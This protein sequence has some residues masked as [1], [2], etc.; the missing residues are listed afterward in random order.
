MNTS[1][2][3]KLATNI[4]KT[5]KIFKGV[6]AVNQLPS[7][8]KNG[9]FIVN[10]DP[11]HKP[12]SHWVAIEINCNKKS[13]NNYY[14]DSYGLPPSNFKI[15]RLL[16]KRYTFNKKKLQHFLSTACGQWCLYFLLRRAQKWNR[17][18]ITKP[19]RTQ[20]SLINDYVVNHLVEKHFKTKDQKVMDK[21]FL[22]EQLCGEQGCKSMQG[23][24]N[25][26]DFSKNNQAK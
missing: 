15:K 2:I 21:D 14:F 3:R 7:K 22:K 17:S 6:S 9:I 4:P 26:K 18:E 5:A 24:N 10:L 13:C 19:F 23:Y 25:G 16:G 1:E 12:G 20:N 8:S 11:S